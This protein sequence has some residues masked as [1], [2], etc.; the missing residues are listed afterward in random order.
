MFF[1]SSHEKSHLF[2]LIPNLTKPGLGDR[3]DYLTHKLRRDQRK[4]K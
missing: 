4:V 3:R 1:Y 2:S